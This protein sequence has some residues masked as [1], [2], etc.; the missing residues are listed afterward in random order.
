MLTAADAKIFYR[1]ESWQPDAEEPLAT[2]YIRQAAAFQRSIARSCMRLSGASEERALAA[3]P[4]YAAPAGTVPARRSEE[5][6][7]P[8]LVRRAQAAFLD[9]LYAFLDGLVHVAFSSPDSL[10]PTLGHSMT[11]GLVA[12]SSRSRTIDVQDKVRHGDRCSTDPAGHAHPVDGLQPGLS[13]RD[14]ARV[15]GPAVRE[16]VRRQ[17]VLGHLGAYGS[18]TAS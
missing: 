16:G 1:L 17:H 18:S 12:P 3:F 11:P 5:P 15:D 4:I 9:A 10:D 2:V 14:V 13:A 6:L 7:P 8:L